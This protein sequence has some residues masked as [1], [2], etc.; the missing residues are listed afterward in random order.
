MRQQTGGAANADG[1][2]KIPELSL[3]AAGQK[4]DRRL[5]KSVV[6]CADQTEA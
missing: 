5:W 1:A 6:L 2:G 3:E 4:Y